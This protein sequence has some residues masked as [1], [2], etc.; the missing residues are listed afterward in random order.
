[1]EADPE[2]ASAQPGVAPA[3]PAAPDVDAHEAPRPTAEAAAAANNATT[4]DG[5]GSGP[6]VGL[7]PATGHG[8]GPGP[9]PGP[10][11]TSSSSEA[12]TTTTTGTTA[13]TKPT[14]DSAS[15]AAPA[16]HDHEQ[17]RSLPSVPHFVAPSS[18]LRFKIPHSNTTMLAAPTPDPK[19]PSPLDK[20]QR[21]G[22]VCSSSL[23]LCLNG[24]HIPY[25]TTHLPSRLQ[26]CS[27]ARLICSRCF[28]ESH[29]R[30]PARPHQLRCPTALLSPHCPRYRPAHQEEL[31]YSHSEL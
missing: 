1:M 31:E 12:A 9:G 23:S 13:T 27:S 7:G 6:G 30:L 8:H 18:Y 10:A 3:P 26:P 4:P 14:L 29:P 28:A 15:S 5:P 24:P 22:L 11:T 21:H 19:T 17:K 20:E 25:P 16:G 2:A